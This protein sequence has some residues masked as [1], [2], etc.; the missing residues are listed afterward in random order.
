MQTFTL[1]YTLTERTRQKI[2][3]EAETLEEAVQTVESYEI[4]NSEAKEVD[5]YEW[6]ICDVGSQ[7]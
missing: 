5:C 7:E 4:D 2:D 6:S 3:I 1:Y